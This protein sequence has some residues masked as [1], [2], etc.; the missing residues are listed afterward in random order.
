MVS[1]VQRRAVV[2]WAQTA[3]QVSERRA[4]HALVVHRALVRYTS[5]KPDDAPLR[6]RLRAGGVAAELWGEAAPRDAPA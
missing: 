4:C 3:Y 2:G 5:V 6:R 1:P